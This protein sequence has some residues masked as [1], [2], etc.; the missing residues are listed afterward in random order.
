MSKVIDFYEALKNNPELQ[1]KFEHLNA[2]ISEDG[3]VNEQELASDITKVANEN[4]YDFTVADYTSFVEE[5]KSS[6]DESKLSDD[7]LEA[8][9]GGKTGGCG[10]YGGGYG[11]VLNGSRKCLCVIFGAGGDN[12]LCL[13][14]NFGGGVVD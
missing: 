5:K 2:K 1:K 14:A 8:V 13:C 12:G 4:G 11:S 10:C 9:A 7:Q 3:D 6:F